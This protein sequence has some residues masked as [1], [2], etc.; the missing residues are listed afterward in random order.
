MLNS[1]AGDMAASVL[2]GPGVK[3]ATLRYWEGV[4]NLDEFL[5]RVFA[6]FEG[7]GFYCILLA[8]LTN[9]LI[10]AFI[11]GFST[12]LFACIDYSIIHKSKMLEDVL[13]PQCL[14]KIHGLPSAFLITFSI[15][16][17]WQF[18]RLLMDIPQLLQMY[19]FYF[20]V[21]EVPDAKM[22]TL[23]WR[24]VVSGLVRA[25]DLP[26]L[27]SRPGFETLD[28]HNIA[29]R[30]MRKENYMI[31]IFNKDV[32]DLTVPWVVKRQMLTQIM[33]W[34]LSFCILSY[35]F[36]ERGHVRKRFL[37]EVNR[38]R[39]INGL[40]QRFILMGILNLICAPFLF[41]LLIMYFFFRY[42]EEFHK[43]PSSL[44][45]RQYTPFARRK[46]RE[47]NEL[48]HLFNHR[49]NRS[50]EKALEYM[51]Q[52]PAEKLIIVA[53]FVAFIS[54]S[55]AAVLLILTLVNDELL[56]GF[57]ITPGRSAFFYIGIFG[58]VMA[59]ARGMVP[60]ENDVFEPERCMR[61]VVEDTHYLPEEWKGKLHTDEVRADFNA[62]FD[63]KVLLFLYE[64]LS[65]VLAPM[66]LMK[67]LPARAETIVDFF[68]EFTVHVDSLGYVCSFAVFDFRKHGNV[69]YG[70]LAEGDNQYYMSNGGKMEQ[71]FMNFKAQNPDWD[72]GVDGSQ[73][74]SNVLS[75]REQ[76]LGRNGLAD[77]A[78]SSMMMNSMM[79]LRRNVRFDNDQLRQGGRSGSQY[80]R[81]HPLAQGAG[82]A[83][84]NGLPP[85]PPPV[86]DSYLAQ[87]E[88][89]DARAM[90][91][92]LFALLDAIAQNQPGF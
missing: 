41:I 13:R 19:R 9:L 53:R 24:D 39:L 67:S 74:L 66:I 30:I 49:L 59:V 5:V 17:T 43:N 44:G 62:L 83:G 71:S 57:E 25:K 92:E 85:Q 10:L 65:L 76:L 52:F 72:P 88:A 91:R 55:F 2:H 54:G 79:R 80:L 60:G 18:L 28:A 35:V 16:W 47:F 77:P 87:S 8:R 70:A 50:Y 82:S 64:V 58:T 84:R 32:L 23:D 48:P 12:F 45:S 3:E 61:E 37:K 81:P 36:N 68:R 33:E 38:T 15:W 73:Y 86:S 22:Q 63:Y 31:A 11:V 40:K 29:N 4:D 89:Y 6:F 14:R 26:D 7:K 27:R 1:F 46:F 51:A 69:K 34:N 42:A 75:K 20:H 21:L 78:G 56:H 90:G